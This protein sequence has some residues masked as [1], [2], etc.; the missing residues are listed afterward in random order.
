M[1]TSASTFGSGHQLEMRTG[2]AG[3]LDDRRDALALLALEG[4]ARRAHP[5][6]A[7]AGHLVGELDVLDQLGRDVEVQ[8][9][10]KPA[11]EIECFCDLSGLGQLVQLYGLARE[12]IG[13]ARDT[14]GGAEQRVLEEQDV[15]T[16]D[17]C[18]A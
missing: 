2:V 10:H 11:V 8:Q 18:V 16:R 1:T 5:L 15:N 4:E 3:V 14:T 17:D 12:G 7:L 6:A 13:E 9:R